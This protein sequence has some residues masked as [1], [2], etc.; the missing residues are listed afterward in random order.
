MLR[1]HLSRRGPRWES[2]FWQLTV[3]RECK[4]RCRWK[5]ISCHREYESERRFTLKPTQVECHLKVKLNWCPSSDKSACD[6]E[7]T[8]YSRSSESIGL[9][10]RE[11]AS[12]RSNFYSII[13]TNHCTDVDDSHLESLSLSFRGAL[14]CSKI[15]RPAWPVYCWLVEVQVL[16]DWS[17][18][19][20]VTDTLTH[21]Q[22]IFVVH[23]FPVK[24]ESEKWGK[25]RQI[26]H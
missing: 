4:W 26:I 5:L 14:V 12:K 6:V 11:G 19:C 7:C 13:R 8:F 20:G 25:N 24:V 21:I 16:A 23:T 15:N 2:C 10:V 22:V 18:S 1:N 17:I 3:D 9:S